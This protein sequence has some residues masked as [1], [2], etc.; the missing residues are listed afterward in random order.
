MSTKWIMILMPIIKMGIPYFVRYMETGSP[1]VY[2]W[3]S[4]LYSVCDLL[5]YSIF[6]LGNYLFVLA[7]MIDF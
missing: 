4:I 7:G 3:D 5:P 2:T 1:L 6:S